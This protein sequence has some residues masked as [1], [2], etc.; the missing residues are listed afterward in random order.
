MEKLIE[1]HERAP[2]TQSNK[3]DASMS[4]SINIES[5]SWW[6]AHIKTLQSS[7]TCSH[8]QWIEDSR[9]NLQVVNP[10]N[11]LHEEEEESSSITSSH[12]Q[13]HKKESKDK[14]NK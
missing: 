13:R 12:E 14:T 11:I 9:P 2:Q 7:C 3:D 10:P 8:N 5:K 6:G 4:T 1:L